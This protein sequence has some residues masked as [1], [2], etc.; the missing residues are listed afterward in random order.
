[1]KKS[2]WYT[3]GLNKFLSDNGFVH[4]LTRQKIT[5]DFNEGRAFFFDSESKEFGLSDMINSD[6]IDEA[7]K[8]TDEFRETG[9]LEF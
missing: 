3:E 8:L 1:M 7:R 9:C 5:D 2:M 6:N 4:Y